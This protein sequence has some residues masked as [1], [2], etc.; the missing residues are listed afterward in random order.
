MNNQKIKELAENIRQGLENNSSKDNIFPLLEQIIELATELQSA[1]Q[2]PEEQKKLYQELGIEA[3]LEKKKVVK[4]VQRLAQEKG[5]KV[6]FKG[7]E[8]GKIFVNLNQQDKQ[9]N[10]CPSLV[11]WNLAQ[12]LALYAIGGGETAKTPTFWTNFDKE[13]EWVKQ[14]VAN[15]YFQELETLT[16]PSLFPVDKLEISEILFI[17]ESQE[18]NIDKSFY[19]SS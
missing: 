15:E 12:Q 1:E 11:F 13:L 5:I 8:E 19:A 18:G 4:E 14:N 17:N 3:D 2:E 7:K 6:N 9:N 10:F 16:A